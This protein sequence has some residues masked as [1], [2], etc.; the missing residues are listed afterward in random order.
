MNERK[1]LLSRI[2]ACDFVLSETAIYLDTHPD[3]KEALDY[4]KKNK[5]IRKKAAEEYTEKF[6]MLKHDDY[7]GQNSWQWTE[8]PW[9][10]EYKED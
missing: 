10:W 4:F 6:G 1:I 2:A 7:S 3:C 8:G 5:E 9:P